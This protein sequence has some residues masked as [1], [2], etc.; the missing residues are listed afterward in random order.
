MD[1]TQIMEE[2]DDKGQLTDLAIAADALDDLGCDCGTDEPGSCLLCVCERAIRKLVDDIAALEAALE[3]ERGRAE[4]AESESETWMLRA[5]SVIEIIQTLRPETTCG[6]IQ[7]WVGLYRSDRDAALA[8]AEKAE[9]EKEI[10]DLDACIKCERETTVTN[11]RLC[12]EATVNFLKL[13]A[14]EAALT[15]ARVD[16][17]K[18]EGDRDEAQQRLELYMKLAGPWDKEVH[19]LKE[20]VRRLRESNTGSTFVDVPE[21]SMF[22]RCEILL[23]KVLIDEPFLSEEGVTLLEAVGIEGCLHELIRRYEKAIAAL[24][25]AR[26]EAVREFAEW[27]ISVESPWAVYSPDNRDVINPSA[28]MMAARFLARK[29]PTDV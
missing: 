20:E 28:E 23:K 4:K 6:E 15:A 18:A 21:H 16:A 26:G 19:E 3:A 25:A 17:V 8:R 29:E 11:S 2:R 27:L 22:G 7:Q 5:A 9:F 12:E 13:Q 10:R 1:W 14:A 24:A